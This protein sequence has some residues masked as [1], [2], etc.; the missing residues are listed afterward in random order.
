[1]FAYLESPLKY[2]VQHSHGTTSGKKVM[3]TSVVVIL[4]LPLSA[5]PLLFGLFAVFSLFPNQKPS[6]N[7]HRSLVIWE[8]CVKAQITKNSAEKK[9]CSYKEAQLYTF[10]LKAE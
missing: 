1:M 8:L 7:S 4:Q 6:H 2:L 3:R 10:I 9:V 5:P